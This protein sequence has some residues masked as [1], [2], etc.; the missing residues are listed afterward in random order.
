MG[1]AGEWDPTAEATQMEA[2]GNNFYKLSGTLP[3][4][5]YEY[6]I[7]I[8]GTWDENY[9]YGGKNGGNFTIELAEETAVT[10]YYH[11]GT[12]A[13]ADTT[14]YSPIPTEKQPRIT[15]DIQPAIN[16]GD[17]WS[18]AT[19]TALLT[20]DNFDN[21]YTYTANV[22]KGNYEY[23]I[24]L[25]NDWGEEYPG[26]NAKLNV[27]SDERIT[28]FFNKETKEVRTDYNPAGSDN[29]ISKDKL[30]HNTWE[31]AYRIPFGAV[32]A[33]EEV[34]LRIASKQDDLTQANVYLKN[35]NTGTSKLLSMKKAGT[36]NGQ[37]FWEA[38]FV[39][40]AKGV[41]GYKFIVHDQEA[42]A[43]YGEDTAEGNTGKA[44]DSNA[45]LFQLTVFDPGYQTPDWMKESVV[46]QIFP[47]RFFNG[48]AT[49]DT[50]KETARGNEPIEH[51]DWTQLPDNPRLVDKEG[52][53]GDEIWSNDFFGGDVKGIQE[54]L[55]YIQS[56][57]VNTIY[58][59]PVAKA[60]SN[61][62]YD[63]TDWKSIDPMFGSPEEFKAFTDELENRGMHLI[64]DGVFN[65]VG[66]DS[67]YFDRYGKYETVGA[68]EYWSLIYDLMNEKG[69]TEDEAKAEARSQL[70]AEGQVFNDEYGFHNW[71]NIKNEKVT[72]E[73]GKEHYDYQAWWGFDSLPE[74]ESVPGDAVNYD[75]ELNNQKFADY[76]MYDEDSAAKKWITNG[77]SGW[78]LDVANEVDME[79]WREFR[80]ELKADEFA[81]TGATLKEGEKP[82]ILGE[83]WDDASKYFLGDQYDSVMNYRFEQAIMGFLKSGNATSTD[84]QL[85]AVKEDYP[86]EAYYA[87]MNLMGSHDTPR[88][89]YVLG[90]GTDS[91]EKA[92][93]DPNYNH[94]L[95]VKRLKLAS[96]I[97]MGYP[98]APTIYYGDEAGVTGSKDPDD[99]RT[100]PWGNE[101]QDL[102]AHYQKVGKVRTSN[103]GLFAYGD[104]ET[105]YAEGDVYAFARMT[106][107][108]FGI[109]AIN[110]GNTA[111]TVELDVKG[112]L[113]NNISLTDQLDTGYAVASASGKVTV[114]VPA[115]SGRMLV[116]DDGQDLS[117]PQTVT[118]LQATAGQGKVELAWNGDAAQYKVYQSTL[119]G[120]LYEEVATVSGNS[121]TIENLANG[122]EYYFA[123][124]A[125]DADGNESKMVETD[126]ATI[127][128]YDLTNAWVGNVT[129]LDDQILDLSKS[130]DINA[131]AWIEGAT[132]NGQA[133]GLIAKLQVKHENDESWTETKATYSG[134]TGNNNRFTAA[135]RPL[136]TGTYTYQYAFSTDS[137]N[138]WKTTEALTVAFTQNT[139]DTNAPAASV[140]LEQPIQESGQVNLSWNLVDATDP[141]LIGI[142]RDGKII[143]LLSDTT[144]TSYTDHAVEN[145]TEY[146]YRVKVF[147]QAGN[148]VTS[149]TVAVTPDIVMVEVTFKVHA[150]EYTPLNTKITMPG[151]QN[152]WSTSAWEMSRNGAVTPDWEITKEF[153]EGTTITYKYVKGES[154]DQEGLPDH[155]RNDVSDDDISYYGY[156]APGTDL[157]VT[158][159]NQGNNKM[160]VNDEILRWIDQPVV[161][162]SPANNSTVNADTVTVKG[163][164]IKEGVLTIN[165]E[166]VTINP[167]MTFAHDVNLDYGKNEIKVSIEPSEENKTEIFKDDGG[168]IGKNTKEYTII[169]N[170][171]IQKVSVKEARETGTDKTVQV[172]GV[173]TSKPGVFG[174]KGFYLQDETGGLYVEA[175]EDLELQA[176]DVVKVNGIIAEENGDFH[177]TDVTV[178]KVGSQ[179]LPEPVTLTADQVDESVEGQLVNLDGVTIEDIVNQE[180]GFSFTVEKDRNTVNVF[181]HE[182]RGL[183]IDNFIFEAG[184]TVDLTGIV[185]Q[186]GEKYEVKPR[187]SGDILFADFGNE[188]NAVIVQPKVKKNKTKVFNKDVAEVPEN[189]K[190]IVKVEETDLTLA[191]NPEQIRQLKE[192]NAE[193]GIQNDD[194]LVM[195]PA[196]NFPGHK[197]TKIELKEEKSVEG[198]ITPVY[199]LSVTQG[200]EQIETFEDKVL[201]AF[202]VENMK[203]QN[204]VFK[205]YNEQTKEWQQLGSVTQDKMII[206]KSNQLTKFAVFK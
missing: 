94:E 34:T 202:N 65:H 109:V 101:N 21:I 173:I 75:S 102:I 33:G 156:G 78:R 2:V 4:G 116:A 117:F 20:D 47:D 151:D 175:T 150:P 1:A 95:G 200:K 79:F 206:T 124:T 43:E 35:N 54:K 114:E 154:W 143:K 91:Y 61:H 170:R 70:E 174:G 203:N 97:Q 10:F 204:L 197:E 8:N 119:K 131:E 130:F 184:D 41:Y 139:E 178:E 19:S 155:T 182:G 86:K 63:A 22:P 166:Q 121:A 158:V 201:A 24:V 193:I 146:T 135:F 162:T 134:Q 157:K 100:Y 169:V 137:G 120:A 55:D 183:T 39:P 16:A 110:R 191:L 83:I 17:G 106:D 199:S 144:A 198:A 105:L 113:K 104:I 185:A 48:N 18:P 12:H 5:K 45:E 9:G 167:D 103:A 118:D 163:N 133:E 13:V 194:V 30:Y 46:Y 112:L 92:E 85:T 176:G 181:I 188:V 25:G 165:G 57:G 192:K 87:L 138:T 99:R 73:D 38:T 74:I 56:L 125:V 205:N 51:R 180:S 14:W 6:K 161:I 31:K 66:D 142:E 80:K 187:Q 28:F 189:G 90:G 141:F 190:L 168:A 29:A 111:Q 129:Q 177:L 172:E 3:A 40:E 149:N 152:G 159:T 42:K 195:I 160:V 58:M 53:N 93:F 62:K 26:S 171:P 147:D 50:A 196:N 32:K 23:K 68:Y 7:A 60:A 164:A 11:D 72:G 89:V 107:N 15:G 127:P 136:E 44:T 128:H 81:G 186:N 64:M 49:N 88:A 115:M 148:T 84:A 96:I 77:G 82:L 69:L 27:L 108:D 36:A 98:G 37:D 71:F 126:E 153:P 145:G 140:E 122:N 123:V 59:N 76:I 67:I 179:E 132:E 52:Y